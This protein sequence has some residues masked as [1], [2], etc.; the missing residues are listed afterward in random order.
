MSRVSYADR[1]R[2]WLLFLCTVLLALIL[3]ASVL[4]SAP[5]AYAK[6]PPDPLIQEIID[7]VSQANLMDLNA[8]LSGEHP[9]IVGG[10][11]YT[12]STRYTRSGPA[13]AKVWQYAYEQFAQR[14]F[15]PSYHDYTASGYSLKNSIG[16]KPGTL[17]PS[18]MYLF[19]AH[20]DSTSGDAYN[21]A[22]GADDNAS[23][24]AALFEAAR[25]LSQYPTDYTVRL[26]AFTGE[27]QGLWGSYAYAQMVRSQNQDIRGVLN[28][29]MIAWDSDNDGA[30]E[31][32]SGTRADS[33][34]V[35][36]VFFDTVTTYNIPLVLTRYTSGATTASDHAAFWQYNY[37]AFLA[38][39]QY[40]GDFNDFYHTVNDRQLCGGAQPCGFNPAY[41]TAYT[42]ALVGTLARLAGVRDANTTPTP[43]SQPTNTLTP[44]PPT[45]TWTPLPS[46]A[47][48][49]TVPPTST[50]TTV[51][52]GTPAPTETAIPPTAT[53]TSTPC[54]ASFND[55]EPGSTFYEYIQGLACM[56]AINGYSDGTFRPYNN[57]TRGQVAKMV[58]LAEG[59][60]LVVPQQPTFSDVPVDHTFY[61][62]VETL[63]ARGVVNGYADGTFRPQNDVTRGQIAKIVVLSEGWAQ[64]TPP[65]PTFS[66]VPAGHTFFNYVETAHEHGIIQG[67]PDG[68]YHPENSATRGQLS[69]IVYLAVTAP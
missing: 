26:V 69:K 1:L 7:S 57:T 16:E 19:V 65:A 44:V 2:A 6:S 25:I 22:P 10:E 49:T 46:T 61:S 62:Y 43:T 15:T 8:G 42:K 9:V 17:D 28:A 4:S 33:N 20:I 67:Y 38:I 32:H 29:D 31:I 11:P 59:W 63:H 60:T 27:E 53:V 34:L 3:G 48:L 35:A 18:R 39:E 58:A 30:G 12:M 5:G 37:P 21:R 23:G 14:G 51:P 13:I 45:A 54:T 66:D 52:T 56:G 50:W 40:Y 36:D 55:V 41:Y 24:S 68:T 64:Y 47:T